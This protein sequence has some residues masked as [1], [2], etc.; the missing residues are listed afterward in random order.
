MNIPSDNLHLFHDYYIIF[1]FNALFT[2]NLF[3]MSRLGK[4]ALVRCNLEDRLDI[5]EETEFFFCDVFFLL[6]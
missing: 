2:H 6:A 1:L 5:I 4:V 3:L